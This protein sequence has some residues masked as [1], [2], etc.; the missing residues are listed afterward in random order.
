MDPKPA[1]TIDL[2]YCTN[3]H[4]LATPET[5]MRSLS[6]FGP[7]VRRRLGWSRMP[8]GLWWQSPLAEAA[9]REPAEVAR[10]LEE[11]NLRAFTCN[12]FPYGNFH[13]PV[14]KTK[15]YHPDWSTP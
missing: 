8:L 5:W 9:A 1:R 10:F 11:H 15:V 12:A 14:V 4:D 3:V 13:E 2:T 7:E 6:Y